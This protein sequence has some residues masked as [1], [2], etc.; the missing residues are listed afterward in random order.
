M[1]KK[2]ELYAEGFE[3]SE[4][5][6]SCT[7]NTEVTTVTYRDANSCSYSD[8]NVHLFN[9]GVNGCLNEYFDSSMETWEEYLASFKPEN[10]GGCYNSFA[11]GNFFA[12]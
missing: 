10:G 8:M 5:I 11:D 6:A 7:A 3:L 9:Q 2:P 12:S 4:H 1:Y